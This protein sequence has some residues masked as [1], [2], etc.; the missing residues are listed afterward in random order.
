MSVTS[1]QAPVPRGLMALRATI[2]LQIG[3]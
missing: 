3:E 2:L 1:Y